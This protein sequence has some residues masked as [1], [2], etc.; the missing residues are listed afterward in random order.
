MWLN[1]NFLLPEGV[2][3][4]DVTFTSLRGGGPL[5]IS[6]AANGQVPHQLCVCVHVEIVARGHAGIHLG[7]VVE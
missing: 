1:Q 4:T 5:S 6:M 7:E 3:S 2:D